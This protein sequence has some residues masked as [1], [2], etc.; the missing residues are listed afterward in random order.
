MLKN[1]E[2]MPSSSFTLIPFSKS[3]EALMALMQL[4]MTAT[5]QAT[6]MPC[7]H[8]GFND[9]SNRKSSSWA[10]RKC[11]NPVECNGPGFHRKTASARVEDLARQHLAV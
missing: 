8:A 4:T 5:A 2:E 3:S 7:W 9:C 10:A 6:A 1:G 11:E